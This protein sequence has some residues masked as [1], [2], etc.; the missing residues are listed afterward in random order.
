MTSPKGVAETT[1]TLR[2][3]DQASLPIGP[4]PAACTCRAFQRL[5]EGIRVAPTTV[6]AF[7]DANQ[8]GSVAVSRSPRPVSSVRDARSR[9]R[10]FDRFSTTVPFLT[11]TLKAGQSVMIGHDVEV[12]LADVR[13]EKVIVGVAAPSDLAVY[14]IDEVRRLDHPES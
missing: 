7:P 4:N 9:R 8:S 12:T 13:T 3:G 2:N 6:L 14:R 5:D 10:A 11:L 1:P